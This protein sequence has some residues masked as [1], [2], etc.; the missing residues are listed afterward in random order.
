MPMR[1]ALRQMDEGVVDPVELGP[2]QLESSD[3]DLPEILGVLAHE[4][5]NPLASLQ[6]CAQTLLDRGDA[7]E[8][9]IRERMT[10][11]IV[12]HSQ[13][14]D[15]LTRAAAMFGGVGR[16]TD[17]EEVM[18]ADVARDACA[19]TNAGIETA[20]TAIVVGNEQ[21]I[22]LAIEAVL[23][24]LGDR[25]TVTVRGAVVEICSPERDLARGSRSWKLHLASRVFRDEGADVGAIVTSHGTCVTIRFRSIQGGSDE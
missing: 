2:E 1:D 5:R 8:P 4:F 12:K 3:V 19:L 20:S 22:Q 17:V 18:L 11:V 6:G 7:L 15:W 21:R 25:A 23:M 24:A 10:E 13:R 14:L 16:R 9:D